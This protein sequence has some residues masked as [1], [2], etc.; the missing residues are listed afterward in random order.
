MATAATC[1]MSTARSPTTW[2]P[3]IRHVLR[4]A[5]S[6]Q[7]PNLR[8][9]MM[10]RTV[11]SKWTTAV[12]TSCASRAFFS[13][14]PTWAYSG[15]VKLPTGL[16]SF[17]SGS[18][19]PSTALVAAKKPAWSACGTSIRRPVMSPAAKMCGA[20][21]RKYS[22]TFTNP[23]GSV[24]TPAAARFR[25]AGVAT[26]PPPPGGGRRRGVFPPPPPP[27]ARQRG[28]GSVAAPVLG[29]VH[30]HA[31]R[32]L[33]ER[34]D[35]AEALAHHHARRAERRRHRRRDV[36]VLA[37]HDARPCLE[38]LD[39]R[40]ERVEDRSDL[41]AR[42]PGTDD[43][44]RGRDRGQPPGVTVRARQF[45]AGNRESAAHATRANDEP[46]RLKPQ[47]TLGFDGSWVCESRGARVLVDRHAE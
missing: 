7:K 22:S 8:P 5:I 6:L 41:H 24:S 14:R 11:E 19:G 37:G 18:V 43:E 1:M 2:Q 46:V 40:A 16:A 33:L 36:F 32:R 25:P 31:R 21:V 47:P 4:S 44:H 20:D 17:S 13:V 35:G 28:L 15:S 12:T 34:L 39:P 26:H 9:S 23:R 42:G 10:V 29:E 27:P 30:A 3:R 38:E 45:E